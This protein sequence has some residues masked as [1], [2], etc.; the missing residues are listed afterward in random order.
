MEHES[1]TVRGLT[2]PAAV[3]SGTTKVYSRTMTRS[4]AALALLAGSAVLA[5]ACG[6]DEPVAAPAAPD[7]TAVASP[8]VPSMPAKPA[9]AEGVIHDG[10]VRVG[11][12]SLLIECE[13]TGTPVVVYET[14]IIGGRDAFR[15]VQDRL[16]GTTTVCTYDRANLGASDRVPKPRTG[17][18]VVDD[19]HALLEAAGVPA[20]YVLV[21]SSAG[22]D[23]VVHHARAYPD[24]VAAVLA[25]NPVLLQP[26]W[27]PRLD[28]DAPAES[29]EYAHE[30]LAGTVDSPEG[31]DW[32]TS[33]E[34]A[35]AL[36]TPTDVPLVLIHS[37]QTQC[38]HVPDGCPGMY[39]VYLELGAEYA[40][41]WPGAVYATVALGHELDRDAPDLVAGL[42]EDFVA[43][44]RDG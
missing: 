9:P 10:K 33:S 44:S 31:V 19:A 14:I 13:G 16:A 2:A 34:Q 22:A 40:A 4:I 32:F 35:A 20:P 8:T 37:N 28:E 11:D 39:P 1:G 17:R 25:W 27:S 42:I 36:P 12:H 23:H 7:A 29:V 30:F 3:D 41:A 15:Q 43:S 6:D 5:A 38:E 24:D 21:G 26:D 18:D